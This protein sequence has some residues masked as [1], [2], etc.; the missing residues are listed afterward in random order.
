MVREFG[1]SEAIGP[2]SYSGPPAR[3]PALAGSRGYS[4]HTQWL[5]DQEVAT[6]LTRA[7][8]RA[9]DLLTSHRQALAQLTDTLL[10]QETV[11]GDQVRVIAQAASPAPSTD[12]GPPF[13]RL[14]APHP[15]ISHGHEDDSHASTNHIGR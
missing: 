5:V 10:E 11:T 13:P 7:E 4:E 12:A 1:L 14:A 2:V 9:L 8:A 3:Y 15:A 6:L